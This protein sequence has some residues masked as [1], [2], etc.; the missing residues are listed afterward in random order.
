MTVIVFIYLLALAIWLGAMVFFSAFIAPILFTR[1]PIAEAGAFLSTLFPRYYILGYVAGAIGVALAA[2]LAIVR[3]PGGWW[4]VAGVALAAALAITVTAG[5]VIRPRVDAIRSVAEEQNP[6]PLRKAEFDRL[7][8][9]SVTLNG[10]VL[11]L[12][13]AAWAATAAALAP[14]G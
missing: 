6:D 4:T 13:L 1:L 12:N 8:K 7:H 10:A 5:T 9:L 3:G 2:Y 11:V 14:R